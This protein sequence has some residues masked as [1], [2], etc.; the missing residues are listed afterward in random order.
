MQSSDVKVE[1]SGNYLSV[2]SPYNPD[3]PASARHLGGRWDAGRKVWSFDARDESAVRQAL[4]ETYGTDGSAPVQLVTIRV[5]IPDA[6]TDEYWACGRRIARRVSR[7]E[8]VRLGDGVVIVA[9]GF[10]DSGG[11]AKHPRLS[12]LAGTV[13]EVR[14]VPLAIAQTEDVEI[15]DTVGPRAMLIEAARVALAALTPEERAAL[16]F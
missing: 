8:D 10:A 15:L 9:G 4:R 12:P 14:D 1:Q 13:L 5:R 7:D 2:T 3:F 6:S 11:S 16:R